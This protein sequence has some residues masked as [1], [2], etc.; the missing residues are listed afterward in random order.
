MLIASTQTNHA[1]RKMAMQD[2][3]CQ[4]TGHTSA[5]GRLNDSSGLKMAMQRLGLD[6]EPTASTQMS[7][8]TALS[9]YD[10]GRSWSDKAPAVSSDGLTNSIQTQCLTAHVPLYMRSNYMSAPRHNCTDYYK[11][12]LSA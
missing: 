5:S 12:I 8:Q 2:P 3:S 10:H 11:R 7:R 6:K 9:Q 4:Y 1:R